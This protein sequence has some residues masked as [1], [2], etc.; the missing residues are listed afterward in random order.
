MP[1]IRVTSDIN[2]RVWKIEAAVGDI[3]AEGDTLIILESMKTELPVDAPASGRVKE[4]LVAE[5]E[6]VEEGRLLA[7]IEA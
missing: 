1:D 6:T 2:G 7:V 4:I 5:E 3:V